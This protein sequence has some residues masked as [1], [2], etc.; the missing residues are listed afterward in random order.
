MPSAIIIVY[1][2]IKNQ[3]YYLSKKKILKFRIY[4]YSFCCKNVKTNHAN[5]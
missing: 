5:F 3:S 2:K 4:L 1:F